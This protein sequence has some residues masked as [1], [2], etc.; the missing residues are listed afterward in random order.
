MQRLALLLAM[1]ERLSEFEFI[2]Q[3]LAFMAIL[4]IPSMVIGYLLGDFQASLLRNHLQ[5]DIAA[6]QKQSVLGSLVGGFFF[7]L[8][9][10]AVG[11]FFDA[12]S[13]WMLSMPLFVLVLSSFQWRV[14]RRG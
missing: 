10:F 14:L 9:G 13:Q 12:R 8:S 1:F 2:A 3:S 7:I 6:W 5:W 11:Y 4:F